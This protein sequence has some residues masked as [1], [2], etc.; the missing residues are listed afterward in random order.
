[1]GV[2]QMSSTSDS[3]D[4]LQSGAGSAYDHIV[5]DCVLAAEQTDGGYWESKRRAVD[6]WADE[7]GLYG[8]VSLCCGILRHSSVGPNRHYQSFGFDS[9]DPYS[10]LSAI[11]KSALV[12]DVESKM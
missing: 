8:D 3:A 12:N 7:I 11:A 4:S 6:V 10:A 9:E 1:M 2:L 5:A